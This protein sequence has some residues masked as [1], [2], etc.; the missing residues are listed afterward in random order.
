MKQPF[1]W[2]E[3]REFMATCAQHGWVY[4]G[5]KI[6]SVAGTYSWD[7]ALDEA[8]AWAAAHKAAE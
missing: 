8:N 1:G 6:P 5:G 4:S 7:H 3:Q 2:S